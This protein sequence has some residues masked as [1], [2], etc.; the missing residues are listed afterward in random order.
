VGELGSSFTKLLVILGTASAATALF[1]QD[2]VSSAAAVARLSK[3]LGV[4]AD[5]ITEW[6]NAV[7]QLGGT[8]GGLQGTLSM[9]SKEQTKISL[10]GQSSLVPYM[11]FL[12]VSMADASGKARDVTDILKDLASAAEGHD[13]K[14]M[15]N[16]FAEVGI[17][18]GTINL[19]LAG[20]KELDITLAH[21]KEYAE[22]MRKFAPEATK[23][24][25]SLVDLKQQFT[26]LGLSLL[27][28]AA[29]ALEKLLGWFERIGGWV[30]GH[31]QFIVDFLKVMAVG[32]AALGLAALPLDPLVLAIGA[33][34]VAIALLWDD[35]QTFQHGGQSLIPWDK[36]KP[37]IDAAIAGVKVLEK[38][39]VTAMEAIAG[40]VVVASHALHGDWGGAQ[41]ALV[42]VTEKMNKKFGIGGPD[43][44]H[45]GSAP[46][47][48]KFLKGIVASDISPEEAAILRGDTPSTKASQA[49]LM[50]YYMSKGKS[51]EDAAALTANAWSESSGD[52]RAIGDH[53][54]AV[55]LMQWHKDRQD[56]F[57]NKYGFDMRQASWQQQADFQMFE[58]S[59]AG[60]EHRA[61]NDMASAG[62]AA[63][64]AAIESRES[65]R[66]GL[67]QAAKD[68]AAEQ[69][70]QLA[71]LLYGNPAAGGYSQQIAQAGQSRASTST[72]N[73]NRVSNVIHSV[74][75]NAPSGDANGIAQAFRSLNIFPAAVAV[76]G[77]R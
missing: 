31:Q 69:R 42:G 64:K 54:A 74:T 21:Q 67:T 72:A 14:N 28:Q 15:H 9:L 1:I 12:G 50:A 10:T 61:G 45:D 53:G 3:N 46:K 13:R 4:G 60:K 23:I 38:I 20:R 17:D 11:N 18:E 6:S 37:G 35:Y 56:N 32:L 47:T 40:A 7:E 2:M 63:Q 68:K 75:I 29:P 51:R 33:L 8:A 22:Q 52:P 36:W 59:S 48:K 58:L 43:E 27:Q 71:R 49:D 24:Q 39:V 55:G 44:S 62:T 25:H 34:G 26:L 57:R 5:E 30:Q 16:I 41:K 73:D 76:V 66:P 70:G 77:V 19:L 65:Q